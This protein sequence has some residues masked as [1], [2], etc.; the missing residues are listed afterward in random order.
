MLKPVKDIIIVEED[1]VMDLIR[2]TR[3]EDI[4]RCDMDGYSTTFGTDTLMELKEE[5][6]E[7]GDKRL[8]DVEHAYDLLKKAGK[9]RNIEYWRIDFLIKR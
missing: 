2:G 8:A 7:T 3:W 1:S 4:L 6:E 5:F 9:E